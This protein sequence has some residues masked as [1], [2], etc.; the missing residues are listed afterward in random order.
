MECETSAGAEVT[1]NFKIDHEGNQRKELYAY[2]N[3]ELIELDF[4]QFGINYTGQNA[5]VT[6]KPGQVTVILKSFGNEVARKTFAYL[7]DTQSSAKFTNPSAVKSW[8]LTYDSIDEFSAEIVDIE[9]NFGGTSGG[10]TTAVQYSG[11]TLAAS[12]YSY[13]SGNIGGGGAEQV[14]R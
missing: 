10:I 5:F 12:T 2:V 11:N 8:V 14:D 3:D 1:V 9:P 7:I 13:R 6:N 4:S